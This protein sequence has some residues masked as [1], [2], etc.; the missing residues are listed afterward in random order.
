MTGDA[1]GGHAAPQ[2]ADLVRLLEYWRRQRGDRLFPRRSDIDPVDF[3]F[4]LDRIAL[5]EIHENPRRYRLRVVGSWWHRTMGLELTGTWIEDLPGVNQR[6]ISIEAYERMI[7]AR[8]PIVTVRD[9]WVDERKL[10][11]EIMHLPLS[12]DGE[13]ISMIITAIGPN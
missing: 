5:T 12:E 10:S 2:H 4:M 8:H 9:A 6:R 11:Y 7:A 1:H 13:H 3:S